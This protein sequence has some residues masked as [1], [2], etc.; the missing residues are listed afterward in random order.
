MSL[1]PSRTLFSQ[2]R[3]LAPSPDPPTLFSQVDPDYAHLDTAR[4]NQIEREEEEEED[5]FFENLGMGVL[6]GIEGFGRSVIGLADWALGDALPEEWE[7]RTFE[8]PDSMVGS[9]VE[10]ITQFGLGLI[11]GLGVAGMV[12]KGA[13]L[14]NASDKLVK[15]AKTI[16]T[17][18]SADFIAFDAHEARLSDFLASH[19][20]TRNAVTQYLASDESDSEF[21][22]RMK[23]VIEGGAIGGVGAA[24]IKGVKALK[25]GKRLRQTPESLDEFNRAAGELQEAL[26]E[27]GLATREGLEIEKNLNNLLPNAT[28]KIRTELSNAK[29]NQKGGRRTELDPNDPLPNHPDC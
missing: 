21:E 3:F 9:L 8:R 11:P 10:G 13:K 6:S 22:G 7:E 15:T 16:T 29:T 28:R 26:I 12:G 27:N 4:Q 23:N 1:F 19:D 18:V 5:G 2:S 25:K 20:V 17:G 24:L 14:L